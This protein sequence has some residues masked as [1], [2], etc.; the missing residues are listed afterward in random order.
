MSYFALN[1]F[2]GAVGCCGFGAVDF[3][4]PAVWEDWKAG[5]TRGKSAALLVQVALNQIGYGP[6]DTDGYFGQKSLSAWKRFAN[7]NG[8][9][10]AAFPTQAG[11]LKLG[12]M[13]SQGGDQGGGGVV[14]AHVEGGVIV[15]GAAPG[16]VKAGMST[17]MMVGIGVLALAAVAGLAIMAKKKKATANRRRRAM[18]ARR[19]MLPWWTPRQ[20]DGSYTYK[21][22]KAR[23]LA[24]RARRAVR[25]RAR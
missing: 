25:R 18:R 7:A 5:G 1:G 13:V 4:A 19:V 3:N 2:A 17:G 20:V 16:S 6:L 12:D 22:R 21:G 8:T 9:G 15:P 23:H 11:I 10:D 24:R 14:T